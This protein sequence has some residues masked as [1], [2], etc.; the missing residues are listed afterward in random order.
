MSQQ[1]FST[2]VLSIARLANNGEDVTS[3][4]RACA[5]ASGMDASDVLRAVL[6][7]AD[8]LTH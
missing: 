3:R 7:A 6:R 1:Q 5:Y 8:R 4:V 2:T